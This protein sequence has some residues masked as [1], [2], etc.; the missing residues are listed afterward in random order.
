MTTAA[1]RPSSAGGA[2]RWPDTRGARDER[3]CTVDGVSHDPSSRGADHRGGGWP[4]PCC[5]WTLTAGAAVAPG[6]RGHRRV[7]RARCP[8]HSAG[9][10]RLSAGLTAGR[11]F[12]RRRDLRLIA[13]FAGPG[14]WIDCQK[15][16]MAGRG[17]GHPGVPPRLAGRL[18]L[19]TH[20]RAAF[21]VR[22]RN[23]LRLMGY[24]ARCRSALA[25]VS[26]GV[27]GLTELS[28]GGG[29][30]SSPMPTKRVK[31]AGPAPPDGGQPRGP[32]CRA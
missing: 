30:R 32:R 22:V 15:I 14:G 17:S 13:A 25:V 6:S 11:W 3:I 29:G 27:A 8:D 21:A 12:R 4:V 19:A 10:S 26:R 1:A 7:Y 28:A 24:A 5:G 31:A 23:P 18:D 9:H 16:L 2:L 20:P